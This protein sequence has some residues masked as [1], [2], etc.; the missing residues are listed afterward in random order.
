MMLAALLTAAALAACPPELGEP[1]PPPSEQLD[2]GRIAL[3][4]SRFRYMLAWE[5]CAVTRGD[6]LLAAER[7]AAA[8]ITLAEARDDRLAAE[9]LTRERYAERIASTQRR[10]ALTAT[11]GI[12][13]AVVALAAG[14]A[15]G[16]ALP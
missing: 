15:L 16:Q 5:D 4:P 8:A 13:G 3:H 7:Q 1:P 6:L 11:L 12:T 2:D 14:V 10:Q 9:R